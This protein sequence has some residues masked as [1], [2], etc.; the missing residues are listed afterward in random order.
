[1]CDLRI[2][3]KTGEI[4]KLARI[5]ERVGELLRTKYGLDRDGEF[6]DWTGISNFLLFHNPDERTL[7]KQGVEGE[8]V[9]DICAA[10]WVGEE[11]KEDEAAMWWWE[12]AWSHKVPTE[13]W[14]FMWQESKR[15]GVQRLVENL[16]REWG[17]EDDVT[18]NLIEAELNKDSPVKYPPY[19][20]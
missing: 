17:A 16:I 15:L 9:E 10:E 6:I 11:W 18:F 7:P 1:M 12:I 4:E 5:C 8:N 13:V 14:Q 2:I 19:P 3:A 20:F